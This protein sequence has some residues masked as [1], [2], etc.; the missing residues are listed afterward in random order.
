MAQRPPRP[1]RQD[2]MIRYLAYWQPALLRRD[3]RLANDSSRSVEDRHGGTL[4]GRSGR[5]LTPNWSGDGPPLILRDHHQRL[6][7]QKIGLGTQ[8]PGGGKPCDSAEVRRP[9]IRRLRARSRTSPEPARTLRHQRARP[10]P[11]LWRT[12]TP[13]GQQ[14]GTPTPKTPRPSGIGTEPSGRIAAN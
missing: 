4:V 1:D 13:P 8:I 11:S 5:Q 7:H 12:T 2:E 10:R 3:P 9:A 6:V 14:A